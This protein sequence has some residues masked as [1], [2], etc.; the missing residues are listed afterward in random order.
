MLNFPSVV[1]SITLSL[2][3]TSPLFLLS[4]KR[5]AAFMMIAV[6]LCLLLW[7]N[8]LFVY[9]FRNLITVDLR[10]IVIALFNV[11][12]VIMLNQIIGAIN[13]DLSRQLNVLF[14]LLTYNAFLLSQA[15]RFMVSQSFMSLTR[16]TAIMSLAL[17]IVFTLFGLLSEFFATHS[18]IMVIF[19]GFVDT[20][21]ARPMLANG[22]LAPLF[23]ISAGVFF[24]LAGTVAIMNKIIQFN[25]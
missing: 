3:A 15:E 24:L 13:Y 18:S 9:F 6:L 21:V 14:P 10:I 19:T 2:I 20:S 5:A 16:N 4:E 7:I 22:I 1:S 23:T 8:L 12:L 25:R 11:M 17:L